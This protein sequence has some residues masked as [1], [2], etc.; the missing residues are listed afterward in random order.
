VIVFILI[1]ENDCYLL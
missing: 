1:I